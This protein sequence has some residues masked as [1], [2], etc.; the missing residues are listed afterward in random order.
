VAEA[1]ND[2]VFHLGEQAHVLRLEGEVFGAG[3]PGQ[4]GGSLGWQDERHGHRVVIDDA[5]RGHCP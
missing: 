4:P 1:A 3:C 2:L 5:A